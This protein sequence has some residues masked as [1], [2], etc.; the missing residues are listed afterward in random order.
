DIGPLE[1][2]PLLAH[3]VRQPILASGRVRY[4]GEPIVAVVAAT[5]RQATDAAEA[6]WADVE[7]IDAVIDPEAAASDAIVLFDDLGTNVVL[8]QGD[9]VTADDLTGDVVVSERLVNQ[10]MAPVPLEGR[11][12]A[13]RWDD[14]RLTQW[15]CTQGAHGTRDGLAAMFGIEH[16]LVHVITPD[17]GG[18]FGAKHGTTPE[19]IMVAWIARRLE[20]P[21]RWAETRSE[22]LVGMVHGRG[23]VQ[24]ASLAGNRDGT[25]TGYRLDVIQEGGAYAGTGCV[26]PYMTRMMAPGCYAIDDVRVR[27]RSVVS[28]T[29]TV[30]AYRG[31]GRPEAAAAIERMVD[32]FADEIGMDPADVRRKNLLTSEAFPLRT[33]TGGHYDSGDYAAVLDKVLAAADYEDLLAKQAERRDRGDT[34][35]I[36]IGLSSYVEITNVLQDTEYGSV[37][38]TPEGGAIVRTGSSAHGQGHHT[39]WAMLVSDRTGIPVAD[40]EVRHGDTIDIPR[41]TGTGGSKSLQIGGAAAAAAAESVVDEARALAARLLEAN[42]DDIVHDASAGT[43]AVA[44]T[45]VS[46]KSWADLAAAAPSA[47]VERLFAENDFAG[48]GSTFPFGA[49]LAVVEVDTETGEVRLLRH[50]ACDDAGTIINPLIFDGQVHGGIAAGASQAL[51]EEF[52]YDEDGNPLTTTLADYSFPSAAEF[53][54]F[55]RIEHETTTPHN[56]LGAKGIGE[57][58]TIGATPAVQNAVVDAVSHLGV[59]HIDMPLTPERV[60]TAIRTVSD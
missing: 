5:A 60:W 32:R 28:N 46:A 19:E 45:P 26:L 17:V 42:P 44:G 27:I 39:A 12:A 48:G 50:V 55:D 54:S 25:I 30:G 53:P 16:D 43:F 47:G 18:G 40:I 24:H 10:R 8:D 31:A 41:G 59:R 36:G 21:V 58:G 33:A 1:S 14:D 29:S 3:Q 35:Q 2:S 37:E 23:Q 38:I 49:H 56:P 34:R 57:A 20:Q 13:A 51:F 4:V 52:R 11:V 15:S 7:P 22:N 9:P 6:V